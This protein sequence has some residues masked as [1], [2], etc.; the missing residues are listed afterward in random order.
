MSSHAPSASNTRRAFPCREMPEPS[1][2]SSGLD[3]KTSTSTPAFASWIAAASPATP[4]PAMA[5]FCTAVMSEP[6]CS[7]DSRSEDRDGVDRGAHGSGD[8]KRRRGEEEVPSPARRTGGGEL[9]EVPHL[10]DGEP[11]VR[12]HHLVE[13]LERRHVELV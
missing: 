8:G 9:V 4:L 2:L 7:R 13:R 5:T 3:S 10:A 11:Q 12:D 6:L 1:A